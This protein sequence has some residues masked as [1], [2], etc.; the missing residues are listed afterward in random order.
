MEDTKELTN[1]LG[2]SSIIKF[3]TPNINL[4]KCWYIYKLDGMI[5]AIIDFDEKIEVSQIYPE[6]R[7]VTNIQRS[8]YI[9]RKQ[10]IIVEASDAFVIIKRVMIAPGTT[11]A[12]Y[13]DIILRESSVD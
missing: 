13:Q 8:N 1:L 11:R 3:I 6:M 2:K 4:N 5:F 9:H 7:L 12:Q 10:D